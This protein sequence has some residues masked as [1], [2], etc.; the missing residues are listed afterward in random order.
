MFIY[1]VGSGYTQKTKTKNEM[2][3]VVMNEICLL[4]LGRDHPGMI[5]NF[6]YR[7]SIVNITVEHPADKVD[8]VLGE[9]KKGDSKGV[10]EN[11]V[12]VVE[13]I[14]LI[15]DG[16]EQNAQ[17]PDVLLFAAVRFALKDFRCRI[18]YNGQPQ[19]KH[20]RVDN[21]PIVPTNT[22]KGPFLM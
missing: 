13:W 12:D 18:I 8:A 17:S 3:V 7:D 15:D 9:W 14:L 10:V 19:F 5:N 6:R 21:L 22:S 11:F 1:Q 16:I 2:T 20:Q 4:K